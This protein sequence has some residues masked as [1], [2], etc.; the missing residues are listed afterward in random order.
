[1]EANKT[2]Q[3]ILSSFICVRRNYIR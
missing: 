3:I 2:N 1:M